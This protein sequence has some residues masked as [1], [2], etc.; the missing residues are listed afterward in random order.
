[1]GAEIS[2]KDSEAVFGPTFS[3]PS[4]FFFFFFFFLRSRGYFG[5]APAR[6]NPGTP[7]PVQERFQTI[8]P[9]FFF[10]PHPSFSGPALQGHYKLRSTK[11]R[12]TP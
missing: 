4:P 1:M 9:F 12:V 2:F 7:R 5:L 8:L 6:D 10:S 11:P 3:F